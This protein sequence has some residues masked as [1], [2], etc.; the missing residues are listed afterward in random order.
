VSGV[1][2]EGWVE[3]ARRRDARAWGPLADEFLRTVMGAAYAQCGDWELAREIAQETFAIAI[4]RI[5]ALREPEAF[6]GWLL[7]IARSC[8][9]RAK[10]FARAS[11]TS[12][13]AVLES[14]DP[15]DVAV[16]RAREAERVRRALEAL[17]EGQ[18]LPVVLHYFAG[19]SIAEIGALCGLPVSTVKRRMRVARSRLR[20]AEEPMD[21]ETL[22]AELQRESAGVR[23]LIQLFVAV[24]AGDRARVSSLLDA[25]PQ[26]VD[27]REAFSDLERKGH[28]LAFGVGGTLLL[29]AIERGDTALVELL[30]ERG[31]DPN[32]AC[33]C[34]GG[35][36]PLWTAVVHR[37]ARIA[38]LLLARGADPNAPA[39]AG[40]SPFWV[41]RARGYGEIADL[42]VAHGADGSLAGE[43]SG[44]GAGAAA[45]RER[46]ESN[47]AW[48]TGIR[49]LDLWCTLPRRGLVR[50]TP[51]P[52]VGSTVLLGELALRAAS[53]G[54][55]VVWAGFAPAP[56]DCGDFVHAAAELG[57]AQRVS[58]RI[59]PHDAPRVQQVATL[60]AALREAGDA[61]LVV[62]E[63]EGFTTELEMRLPELASRAGLS[64]VA[65]PLGASPPE[66]AGS[67][68]LA[69]VAFD[70]A[71]ASRREWP[72]VGADGSWSRATLP[73]LATLT[74]RSRRALALRGDAAAR[75][76][77][78]LCQPFFSTEPFNRVA[79]EA[80]SRR[81]FARE[82]EALL[83][84]QEG[85]SGL[86]APAD[87]NTQ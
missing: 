71:R 87:P 40:A 25:D 73:E 45:Q 54:M 70:G 32:A 39:F 81:D 30:L 56:L 46:R 47:G 68:Y 9:S 35:E 15:P 60:E 77:K 11:G 3:R 10:R 55:G 29:R 63:A 69:S 33:D 26:L 34:A 85:A 12:P 4:D 72:A 21:E 37:R 86:A 19:L 67:P 62:F 58:L 61:L 52:A 57:V 1:D 49:A 78:W 28:R 51:R 14:S 18:R 66:P 16:G 38:A 44:A 27:A 84:V 41:A 6:P 83:G 23:T 31:A 13:G 76:Q 50:W 82:L 79:G 36:P 20:D 22:R 5:G 75:L 48:W 59:P 17:P 43:R 53:D 42:L 64:I 74:A 80:T 8:A 7:A 2:I 24:R 65:A